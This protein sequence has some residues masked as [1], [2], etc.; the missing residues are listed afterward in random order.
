MNVLTAFAPSLV[1]AVAVFI[2]GWLSKGR[3]DA[4]DERFKTVDGRFDAVDSRFDAV[5]EQ[6]RDVREDMR[7]IR[8]D[9]AGLRSDLTHVALAVGAKARPET[10]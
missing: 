10:A 5:D 9:V 3:F 7:Q 6:F 8:G 2:V 1:A 4:I